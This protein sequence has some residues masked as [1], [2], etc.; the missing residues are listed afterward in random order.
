LHLGALPDGVK[1]IISKTAEFFEESEKIY[2]TESAP[3]TKSK[4]T[5]PPILQPMMTPGSLEFR[6]MIMGWLRKTLR[7]YL[8]RTAKDDETMM[9]ICDL[10]D[11]GLVDKSKK[12]AEEKD[13][14][15]REDQEIID[16]RKRD[17]IKRTPK[18]TSA[19]GIRTKV[20]K[21]TKT[22]KKNP[23]KRTMINVERRSS[24]LVKDGLSAEQES[25]RKGQEVIER[26]TSADSIVR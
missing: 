13:L 19:T 9:K 17:I 20:K 8:I 18:M 22:L 2:V 5:P 4:N 10:N 11:F 1:F 23:I 26:P 12:T 3:K 6:N 25:L 16:L 24:S 15:K 14:E 21:S 7:M